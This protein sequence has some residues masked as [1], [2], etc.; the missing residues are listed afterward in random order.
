MDAFLHQDVV[1]K[2]DKRYK[3]ATVNLN[4]NEYYLSESKSPNRHYSDRPLIK[5]RWHAGS[6]RIQ[7]T[8][9]G[10]DFYLQSSMPV[11]IRTINGFSNTAR[12]L[13]QH[14]F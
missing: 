12:L 1:E 6:N 4:Y 7:K 10:R 14:I 11:N 9:D 13:Q 5:A 8:I 2:Q 3:K